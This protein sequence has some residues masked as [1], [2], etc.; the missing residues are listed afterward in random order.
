MSNDESVVSTQV[1]LQFPEAFWS[2]AADFF[3]AALPGGRSAR[4]ACFMFWNLAAVAGAP[5]LAALLSGQ[6]ALVRG[7]LFGCCKGELCVFP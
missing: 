5:V 4:G 2:D 7:P 1:V 3:G 6:A